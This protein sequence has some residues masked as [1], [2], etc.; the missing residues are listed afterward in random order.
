MLLL[1][2]DKMEKGLIIKKTWAE[3]AK[4]LDP[5][6]SV[7]NNKSLIQSRI[8]KE[9]HNSK[10]HKKLRDD[11]SKQ[12]RAYCMRKDRNESK[13]VVFEK[14]SKED[15]DDLNNIMQKRYLRLIDKDPI[16]GCFG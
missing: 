5:L 8:D 14:R 15:Q 6:P 10:A 9:F 12:Q 4:E 2:M 11:K 13:H 16:R 3:I 1:C 7:S